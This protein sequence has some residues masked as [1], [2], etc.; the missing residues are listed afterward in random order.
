M[1]GEVWAMVGTV[2]TNGIESFWSWMPRPEDVAR[3][4]LQP[5]R[6]RHRKPKQR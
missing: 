6:V 1:T 3:S 4:V 2:H 5:V